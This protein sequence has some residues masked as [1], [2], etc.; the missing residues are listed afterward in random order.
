MM[1]LGLQLTCDES[2]KAKARYVLATFA[3]VLG[4]PLVEYQTGARLAAH[5]GPAV[6]YG[7]LPS[8]A[9]D[10]PGVLYLYAAPEAKRLFAG[11]TPRQPDEV[12][13]ATWRGAEVPFLFPPALGRATTGILDTLCAGVGS[14]VPYDLVAS[15]FYWLSCWEET[16]I[17]DRDAHGRFPYRASLAAQ[18]GLHDNVVD[19]YLELFIAL[20]NAIAPAGRPQ[21]VIPSWEG[22]APFVVCL[23]H[24]VDDVRLS[25]A[26]RLKFAWDQL[27]RR[28]GTYRAAAL[29]TRAQLGWSTVWQRTDPCWTYPAF[30]AL[31][32]QH[33]FT[34]TY[35]WQAGGIGG[36]SRYSLA[37]PQVCGLIAE[38]ESGGFEV[39]LH[40]T[41]RAAFDE[42][43]FNREKAALSAVLGREP[44]G[45]RQ[46]YLRMQCEI[47]FPIYERAGLQ[48]DTTLGYAEREGYRNQFS[49]PYWPFNHGEQR[50]YRFLELPTAIMDA[51]LGG[52]RNLSADEAWPVIEKWL[53]RVQARRGCLTLLWHNLW[54]GYFAGYAELYARILAWISQAGGR[55]LAGRE[56]VRQWLE[57]TSRSTSGETTHSVAIAPGHATRV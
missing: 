15:A 21:L 45:H 41:Y 33:G 34:A 14:V 48:Y 50:P 26:R 17:A 47:T 42:E 25:R 51:T 6:R 46:H 5:D 31:E 11:N 53:R 3:D 13:Y 57:R 44:V 8:A 43:Q 40:G 38:L 29:A 12:I 18:L 27:T 7:P 2:M 49:Y 22:D 19:L 56:I 10:L 1:G 4:L 32:A 24:D 55:G 28:Q 30:M 39:G 36:G 54:E 9:T 35:N 52:Y 37:E 23:T 20:L 16:V